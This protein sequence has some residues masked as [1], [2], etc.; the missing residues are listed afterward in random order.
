MKKS[1]ASSENT[2]APDAE[3]SER[4]EQVHEDIRGIER[5]MSIQLNLLRELRQ[6]LDTLRR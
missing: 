2:P 3:K 6:R 5:L 1:G 4:W